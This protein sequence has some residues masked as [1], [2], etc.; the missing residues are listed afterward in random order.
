[1]PRAWTRTLPEEMDKH[2]QEIFKRKDKQLSIRRE[3]E[4]EVDVD[5]AVSNQLKEVAHSGNKLV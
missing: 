4:G 1:M 5:S 3:R 2:F